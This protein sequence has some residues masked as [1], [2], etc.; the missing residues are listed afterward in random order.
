MYSN[1]PN[2]SIDKYIDN[3]P[4]QTKKILQKIRKIAHLSSK[5]KIAEAIKYGVATMQIDGKNRMHFGA[6]PHHVAIYPASDELVE[7]IPE[8]NDYRTGKGTLTF[9]L[10]KPIPYD[11][12]EKIV[13]Y[14]LR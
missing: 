12:I 10:D 4:T 7:A 6:Y 5:A 11:L 2:G 9:P 3:Y 8:A 13:G 14:L 1:L